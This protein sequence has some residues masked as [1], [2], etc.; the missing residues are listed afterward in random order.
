ME[1]KQTMYVRAVRSIFLGGC[2][3]LALALIAVGTGADACGTKDKFVSC[4]LSSEQ[5]QY[6]FRKTKP[7]ISLLCRLSTGP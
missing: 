1:K 5:Q 7:S 2:W 3:C 6:V 4:C